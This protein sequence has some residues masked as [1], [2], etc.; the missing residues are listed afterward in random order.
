MAI[1]SG[2]TPQLPAANI[3]DPQGLGPSPTEHARSTSGVRLLLQAT[4]P[5]EENWLRFAIYN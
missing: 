3:D 5:I 4:G 2:G 1:A